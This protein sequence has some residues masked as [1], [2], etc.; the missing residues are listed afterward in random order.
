MGPEQRYATP[1]R[2]IAAASA[3]DK[4]QIDRSASYRGDVCGWATDDLTIVGVNG[5]PRI[6]GG[7]PECS[8]QSDLGYFRATIQPWETSNSQAPR[9][10]MTTAR[11]SGRRAQTRRCAV[12]IFMATRRERNNAETVNGH[13]LRPIYQH[14]HP[15]CFETRRTTGAAIDAGAF[16][17][18]G[19]G[20]RASSCLVPTSAPLNQP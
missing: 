20:E 12:A 8:W 17:F 10:R 15:T 3:G 11:P 4:I 14:V 18:R 13:S 9:C 5:R 1:Y 16:E 19:G 6:E 2:A 7:G